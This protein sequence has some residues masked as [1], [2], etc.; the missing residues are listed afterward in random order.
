MD[1]MQSNSAMGGMM[2]GLAGV[3]ADENKFTIIQCDNHISNKVNSKS[4]RPCQSYIDIEFKKDNE[5]SYFNY[6][7]F[8]NFYCHQITIK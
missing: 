4:S 1:G 2:S 5:T 3:G 7:I 8:Q 6:L